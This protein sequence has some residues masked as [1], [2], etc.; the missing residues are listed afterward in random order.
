MIT[1]ILYQEIIDPLLDRLDYIRIN[2]NTIFVENGESSVVEKLQKRY[3]SAKTQTENADDQRVDLI[4]AF[5][6]VLTQKKIYEFW[7]MLRD[8]GLL[9]FMSF[10]PDTFFELRDIIKTPNAFVDMHYIGDWM[11]QL[12][13]SDPVVDR[14]E[15][16]FAYDDVKKMESDFSPEEIQDYFSSHEIKN[17]APHY[18]K[19][20]TEDHYPMTIEVI[21]GHAWKVKLPESTEESNEVCVPLDQILKRR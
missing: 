11:K 21:Y 18:E 10:G 13:F 9:L 20:K 2:P 12:H 5:E 3:T 19:Y 15:I 1:Q 17:I 14:D 7:R 16:I 8:D 4:I 6:P